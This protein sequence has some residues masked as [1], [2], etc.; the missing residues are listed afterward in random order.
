MLKAKTKE[1]L[2]GTDKEY[3]EVENAEGLRIRVMNQKGEV[4]TEKLLRIHVLKKA[5]QID[6][7]E[8]D[9]YFAFDV[10]WTSILKVASRL[11]DDAT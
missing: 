2:A 3:I 7:R 8:R 4:N 1:S 10:P 11:F 5:P 9:D 6:S